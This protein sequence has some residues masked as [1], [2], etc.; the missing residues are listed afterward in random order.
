MSDTLYRYFVAYDAV[1]RRNQTAVGN[2]FVHRV[3][4]IASIEDIREI[5]ALILRDNP[6]LASAVVTNFV[7]VEPHA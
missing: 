6:E 2:V 5:Q 1:T 3:G 7:Q 4:P